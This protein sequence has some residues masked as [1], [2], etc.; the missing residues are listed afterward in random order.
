MEALSEKQLPEF[1]FEE[2]QRNGVAMGMEF[3]LVFF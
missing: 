3:L 2:R 1:C